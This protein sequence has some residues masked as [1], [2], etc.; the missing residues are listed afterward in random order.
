MLTCPCILISY[1]LSCPFVYA[2]HILALRLIVHVHISFWPLYPFVV[3]LSFCIR[4]KHWWKKV[5]NEL[6][7]L[8]FGMRLVVF[9]SKMQFNFLANATQSHN[10]LVLNFNIFLILELSFFFSSYY[11]PPWQIPGFVLDYEYPRRL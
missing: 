5:Q 9:N 1:V 2:F 10:N 6:V 8:C 11:G 4:K 7:M 3:S